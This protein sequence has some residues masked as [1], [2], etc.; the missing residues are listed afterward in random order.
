MF[1][2]I[3]SANKVVNISITSQGGVGSTNYIPNS[4]NYQFY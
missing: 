1:C 4:L 3:V 2:L